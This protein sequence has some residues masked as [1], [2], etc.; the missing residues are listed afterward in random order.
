MALVY[1]A[2]SLA[3]MHGNMHTI[4]EVRNEAIEIWHENN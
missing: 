3:N 1:R 2:Y 4:T